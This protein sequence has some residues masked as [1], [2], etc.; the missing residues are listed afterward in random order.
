MAAGPAPAISTQVAYHLH[1][2]MGLIG[3]TLE[4]PL[5]GWTKVV[6]NLELKPIV[7]SAMDAGLSLESLSVRTA[8]HREAV[9]AFREKRPPRFEH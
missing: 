1:P 4:H 5:H 2:F 8:H 3:L 9:T 6:A 7:H